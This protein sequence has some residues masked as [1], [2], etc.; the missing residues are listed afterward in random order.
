MF[1]V[2]TNALFNGWKDFSWHLPVSFPAS[3]AHVKIVSTLLA[4]NIDVA[5][6]YIILES[7]PKV[8]DRVFIP[9]YI[10]VAVDALS[11]VCSLTLKVCKG[12]KTDIYQNM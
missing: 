10:A 3:W 11:G 2:I 4:I 7:N 5:L 8:S 12:W 9:E 1:Q 6:S